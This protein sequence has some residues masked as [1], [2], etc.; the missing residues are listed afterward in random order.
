MTGFS[1][2]FTGSMDSLDDRTAQS[3]Q[4]LDR[5]IK[6]ANVPADVVQMMHDLHFI[7][8]YQQLVLKRLLIELDDMSYDVK[9]LQ[10]RT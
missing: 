9:R 3:G 1:D 8:R 6:N 4:K 2:M 10:S 5:I 7:N